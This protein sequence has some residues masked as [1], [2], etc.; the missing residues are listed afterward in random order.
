[1]KKL[2]DIK[3]NSTEEQ[4]IEFCEAVPM[5][6]DLSSEMREMYL[7]YGTSLLT[8]KQEEKLLAEQ[9]TYNQK[10]LFWSRALTVGTW[11][12]VLVTLLLVKCR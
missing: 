9:N 10:Q 6:P 3:I 2:S 7:H 4:I 1:M 12:L 11:A 8:L 5:L